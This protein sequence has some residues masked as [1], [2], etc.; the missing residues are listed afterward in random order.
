MTKIMR[1]VLTSSFV[2]SSRAYSVQAKFQ[3]ANKSFNNIGREGSKE[4]K[5]VLKVFRR[6][7]GVSIIVVLCLLFWASSFIDQ[8][9]QK[10]EI[11][12]DL[13]KDVRSS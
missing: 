4:S 1:S 10:P 9:A 2:K 5:A 6:I 11:L 8:P 12:L 13:E 7:G 3:N